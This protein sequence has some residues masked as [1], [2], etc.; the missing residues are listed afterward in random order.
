MRFGH[1]DVACS[2]VEVISFVLHSEYQFGLL[3]L[4]APWI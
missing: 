3:V 1:W 2:L 4:A